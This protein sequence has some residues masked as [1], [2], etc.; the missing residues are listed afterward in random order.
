M[1][2]WEFVEFWI[3]LEVEAIAFTDEVGMWCERRLKGDSKIFG[4]SNWKDRLG[5]YRDGKDHEDRAGS[6]GRVR[7][8]DWTCLIKMKR[9]TGHLGFRGDIRWG[10][11][12]A[13]IWEEAM[14]K[15][16]RIL[17]EQSLT[18]KNQV[19]VGEVLS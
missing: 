19:G 11:T 13:E 8:L 17:V 15:H 14:E 1:D 6:E 7:I 16:L 18:S 5:S 12:G 10:N 4:L 2:V 9:T 3:F